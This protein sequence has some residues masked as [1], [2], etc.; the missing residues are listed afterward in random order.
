[1]GGREREWEREGD[2]GQS[3]TC[4]FA[5]A[6]SGMLTRPRSETYSWLYNSLMQHVF[7][8][9]VP[10]GPSLARFPGGV[11]P[12]QWPTWLVF[13][14]AQWTARGHT[15]DSVRDSQQYDGYFPAAVQEQFIYLFGYSPPVL[16]A[17]AW[18]APPPAST[19][20]PHAAAASV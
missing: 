6:R 12:P 17:R 9:S 10:S 5:A 18:H 1:M 13:F 8:D 20:S 3:L 11:L 7:F 15:A 2:R 16:P 4:F 14:R 19:T